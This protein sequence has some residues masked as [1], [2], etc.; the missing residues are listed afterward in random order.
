M[1]VM[2]RAGIV[3]LA[4][5]Y[6]LSFVAVCLAAC[7]AGPAMAEHGCCPGDDG[8]RAAD[9]DCCSV[10]PGV[11]HGGADVAVAVP[12]AVPAPV[13]ASA[14]QVMSAAMVPAVEGAPSPPLV[15]RV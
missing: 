14:I 4:V 5:G 15:L 3:L 13:F 9:R 2:R 11:S 6:S 7:L 12:Q 10:T 8:I 1:E